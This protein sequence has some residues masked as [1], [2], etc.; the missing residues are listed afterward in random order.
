MHREIEAK[1]LN[2]D[3]EKVESRIK[4]LG[5]VLV[6]E[7]DLE[8]VIWWLPGSKNGG[9]VRVRKS[10]EGKI[11]ITM[12]EKVTDGSGYNEWESKIEKYETVIDVIDHLITSPDLRLE[13]SHHRKD[14]DLDGAEINIDWFPKLN[15]LMEIEAKSEE[16]LVEI[17]EKIGFKKE[18][19]VD[20]GAVSLLTEKLK[21]KIGDKIKL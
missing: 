12:K 1:I 3:P 7:I 11:T 5:G 9:S 15:P 2:I 6:R 4:E 19:L 17:A 8:Q 16:Q 20:R 14:W 13:F 18:Q 21:L 10:S